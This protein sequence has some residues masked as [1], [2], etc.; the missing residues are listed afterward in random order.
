MLA[1]PHLA[2]VSFPQVVNRDP[3]AA[4]IAHMR[5]QMAALRAENQGLKC[6]LGVLPPTCTAAAAL[7]SGCLAAGQARSFPHCAPC[8][9]LPACRARLGL[10]DGALLDFGSPADEVLRAAVD[11]L[12]ARNCGLAAEN[13]RLRVEVVRGRRRL[14]VH[15]R[16]VAAGLLGTRKSAALQQL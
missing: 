8:P 3:V 14:D 16:D 5:Q 4:Q 13:K 7:S 6:G 11:D 12:E 10:G 2:L 1:H 15:E 9:P